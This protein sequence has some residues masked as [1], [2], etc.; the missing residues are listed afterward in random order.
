[1]HNPATRET[2]AIA[3]CV[4]SRAFP[5]TPAQV[6]EAR[7][8]LSGILDGCPVT[9]DAALCLSDLATCE[10]MLRAWFS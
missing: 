10:R 4:W 6:R 1:M 5:A 8:F 9:D 3:A 7:Q 2:P